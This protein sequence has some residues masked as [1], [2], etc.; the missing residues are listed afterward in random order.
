[1]S[2]TTVTTGFFGFGDGKGGTQTGVPEAIQSLTAAILSGGVPQFK[3]KNTPTVNGGTQKVIDAMCFTFDANKRP[4]VMSLTLT[5]IAGSTTVAK[6]QGEMSSYG[7]LD[8][9]EKLKNNAPDSEV[10]ALLDEKFKT[11]SSKCDI[12]KMHEVKGTL[13][14]P[15][16]DALI[17]NCKEAGIGVQITNKIRDVR[18]L[19]VELSKKKQLNNSEATASV[20]PEL[21]EFAGV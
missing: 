20:N 14:I 21:K 8:V 6:I 18:D 7:M 10:C 17:N 3:T 11:Y 15:G 13:T 2:E 1:M 12:N 5:N 19:F 4:R 9:F 16:I